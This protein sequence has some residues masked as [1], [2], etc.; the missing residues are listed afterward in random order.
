MKIFSGHSGSRASTVFVAGSPQDIAVFIELI[1]KGLFG[2]LIAV[3][4][5]ANT[6]GKV[7]GILT[8]KHICNTGILVGHAGKA[9]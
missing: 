1:L 9:V 8:G 6:L 2:N 5:N 7:A 4:V 3:Q